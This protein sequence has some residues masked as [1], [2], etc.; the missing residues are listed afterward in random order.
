MTKAESSVPEAATDSVIRQIFELVPEARD[1][2]HKHKRRCNRLKN[3]L[4]NA[5][6]T[7][8]QISSRVLSMYAVLQNP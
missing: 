6:N 8:T 1:E 4:S 5:Q 3:W 2:V 7:W